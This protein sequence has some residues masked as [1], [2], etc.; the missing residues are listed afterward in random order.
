MGIMGIIAY[1]PLHTTNVVLHNW[2]IYLF[3]FWDLNYLHLNMFISVNIAPLDLF[4]L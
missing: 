3:S 4:V 1:S 2:F